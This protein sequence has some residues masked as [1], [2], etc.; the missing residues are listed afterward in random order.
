MTRTDPV[1]IAD[2]RATLE[3]F[4]DFQRATLLLKTEGLDREQLGRRLP[5][6]ELTLAGLLKHLAY[7]EDN[8]MQESFLGNPP[9]EPWA[10]AP[11]DDD[12]D[13]EFHSAPDDE[14]G[15]LRT[16]YEAA[17]AR[18]RAVSAAAGLD[19]LSVERSCSG[20]LYSLRW[21]LVHLI[22]ETSRHNGHADLLRESIDGVVG[23]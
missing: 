23:E 10:S 13:W 3:Q 14:P 1:T 12:R 4:L 2:E 21:I 5:S 8:W 11:W 15:Y 18:S 17:C 6:S 9:A 20:E 16:L 22:E 7:V 19:D